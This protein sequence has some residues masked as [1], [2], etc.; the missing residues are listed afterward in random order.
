E[1][2]DPATGIKHTLEGP[3]FSTKPHRRDLVISAAGQHI[4]SVWGN[5]RAN[6]W[7]AATGQ[8]IFTL[9][10][11]GSAEEDAGGVFSFDGKRIV[12]LHLL[13]PS[14]ST[15]RVWDVATGQEKLTLKGTLSTDGIGPFRLAISPDG[16]R[17]VAAGHA[18]LK[19]WE[20][21]PSK[22]ESPVTK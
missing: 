6:L 18:A 9:K 20:A 22:A 12:S 17:I 16:Q 3:D 19:V 11:E 4:L 15:L 13:R 1:V 10:R 5:K 14:E 2:F 8:E 7:D 21:P